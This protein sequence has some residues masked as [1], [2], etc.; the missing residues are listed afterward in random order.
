MVVNRRGHTGPLTVPKLFIG[1]ID[2]DLEESLRFLERKIVLKKDQGSEGEFENGPKLARVPHFPQFS[3]TGL[4]A[5]CINAAVAGGKWDILRFQR[6][7][8]RRVDRLDQ[9]FRED[10]ADSSLLR[11]PLR[12]GPTEEE[13][14][15]WENVESGIPGEESELQSTLR[16]RKGIDI[17]EVGVPRGVS[18]GSTTTAADSDVNQSRSVSLVSS[19]PG[20]SSGSRKPSRSR[21]GNS[22]SSP[23]VPEPEASGGGSKAANRRNPLFPALF[24]SCG[25]EEE[26]LFTSSCCIF[27]SPAWDCEELFKHF[28]FPYDGILRNCCADFFFDT[29]EK[30]LNPAVIAGEEDSESS[31]GQFGTSKQSLREY[32]ALVQEKRKDTS[33]GSLQEFYDASSAFAI[34]DSEV[35]ELIRGGREVERVLL[36][37]SGETTPEEALPTLGQEF[38]TVAER[39]NPRNAILA[40]NRHLQRVAAWEYWSLHYGREFDVLSDFTGLN[41]L[42]RVAMKAYIIHKCNSSLP[43]LGNPYGRE[44][45]ER[46]QGRFRRSFNV[47]LSA[48]ND[49]VC[50][51][52]N[53]FLKIDNNHRIPGFRGKTA[54]ELI[55]SDRNWELL[56]I[57]TEF[58]THLPFCWDGEYYDQSGNQG[59]KVER[60]RGWMAQGKGSA[61]DRSVPVNERKCR[62]ASV[63]WD[64]EPASES[65][66]T[67]LVKPPAGSCENGPNTGS[68]ESGEEVWD[69]SKTLKQRAIRTLVNLSMGDAAETLDGVPLMRSWSERF[70]VE[71]CSFL[72]ER[73]Y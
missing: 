37:E 11:G 73:G 51:V 36:K 29:H 40:L 67:V 38:L 15:D 16:L 59:G 43:I 3:M 62:V 66:L 27:T 31:S 24:D 25:G 46:Y 69:E 28:S 10:G 9:G 44:Y 4:S 57:K 58:G 45:R 18:A 12:L 60:K 68:S 2:E 52:K 48:K 55:T 22:I 19:A 34:T 54:L 33:K 26:H 64:V 61:E 72:R 41:V 65:A 39:R 17:A 47:S 14:G 50:V 32:F 70:M 35:G 21:G 8:R 71:L 20:G 56:L 49:P 6:L 23:P 53:S 63:G 7:T 1:G 30:V 13:W 42:E 5:G